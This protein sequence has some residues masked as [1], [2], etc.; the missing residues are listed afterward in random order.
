M[1]DWNKLIEQMFQI[2]Q[3]Y[4]NAPA[5]AL[6]IK[7]AEEVGEF[8]EIM[9]HEF[10][11]LHHKDKEWKD[12][13]IEEAADIMNV[14]VGALAVHYPHK[15]PKQLSDELSAAMLKKGTKYARLLGSENLPTG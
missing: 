9:L 11:F 15:T 7:L 14:L 8:S 3:E 12:T 10:G 1:T 6:T 13:P 2:T 5:F 4:E